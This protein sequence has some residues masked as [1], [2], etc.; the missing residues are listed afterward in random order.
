ME[1]E[2]AG[3]GE[4]WR[5]KEGEPEDESILVQRRQQRHAALLKTLLPSSNCEIL[6][7]VSR[8]ICQDMALNA[9]KI[10]TAGRGTGTLAVQHKAG[11]GIFLHSLSRNPPVP[12][13]FF[14]FVIYCLWRLSFVSG[15]RA[16][17]HAS[18]DFLFVVFCFCRRRYTVLLLFM[19]N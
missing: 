4:Q 12:L 17:T 11:E 1:R 6:A 10:R 7:R 9:I 14:K 18:T 15:G 16:V 13:S 19:P 5:E 2:R 3:K 8:E